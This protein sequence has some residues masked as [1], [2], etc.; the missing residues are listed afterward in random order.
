MCVDGG[1]AAGLSTEFL[2]F[3]YI[4]GTA[5]IFAGMQRL[6][7][8][9][10]LVVEPGGVPRRSTYWTWPEPAKVELPEQEYLERLAGELDEAVRLRLRS[11]VPLG[12]FLSG[13]LDSAAV[14]ALMTK[15]STRPVKTF[16]IGFGDPE[17]DELN[18]ARATAAVFNA[19]HHEWTVTP[20][21]IP[22]AERL[23]IHYDEPF[24]DASAIPTYFV[25]E[26]ARR[27][28]RSA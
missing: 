11:D 6:A 7:P 25:A 18:E 13:G 17:Y 20:D 15:H 9:S 23:A 27:T 21:C 5:G 24:A 8:G 22:V 16:S 2:T 26:L 19:D 1:G 12:A 3:G 28:S 4:G 14:L 10:I